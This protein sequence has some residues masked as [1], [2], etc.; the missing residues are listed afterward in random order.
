MASEVVT[1][2]TATTVQGEAVSI[3]ASDGVTVEGA[4][5][6]KTD[7]EASNGV[8]HVIDTV[9]LPE[10]VTRKL[11][12]APSHLERSMALW[13]HWAHQRSYGP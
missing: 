8:I 1:L 11:S 13:D 10:S 4:R 2:R 3:V 7:I 6:I 12:A 5:V 9:I